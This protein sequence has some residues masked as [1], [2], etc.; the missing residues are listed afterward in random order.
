M[1]A[2]VT[3]TKRTGVEPG[4]GRLGAVIAYFHILTVLSAA[5]AIGAAL[6][7]LL[8]QLGWHT[9]PSNPWLASVGATLMS[10]GFHRTAQFLR[11]RRRIGG[12]AAL[13]CFGASVVPVL[14]GVS[15]ALLSVGIA[16]IGIAAL[17]SVWRYLR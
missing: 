14:N 16:A 3:S 6:T 1:T 11:L 10:V 9:R 7:G 17:G 5:I 4:H 12:I 13:I 2:T 8:P 15:S